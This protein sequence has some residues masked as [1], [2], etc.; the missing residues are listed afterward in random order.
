RYDMEHR[1]VMEKYIGRSLAKHETVHHINGDRS[2]NRPE[3]LQLR[4]GK[5]G[6]GVRHRCAD[7]GSFNVV[8]EKLS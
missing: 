8:S 1:V 7:C 5:H 4:T 3:N 2:D 6:R